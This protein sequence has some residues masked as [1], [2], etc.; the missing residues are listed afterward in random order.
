MIT[1]VK[2]MNRALALAC[3]AAGRTS[4]NPMVGCVIVRRGR[5]IAEG[6][7]KFC[8][9]DHAEV[10]ALKN[11][12]ARAKGADMYVTLEPCA[13]TGRTPPC[14]DAVI[15][16]G[17]RRIIIAMKDPDPRTCGRSIKKLRSHGIEVVTGVGEEQAREINAAFIKYMTSGL[18]Y[19]VAKSAQSM[20]GK[21]GTRSGRIRW[22]TAPATRMAGRAR[23][24]GFDAIVVG[25]NTVLADDPALD[26]PGKRIVKV[27]VDTTLRIP[28]KA[29]IFAGTV[30]GQVIAAT[31]SRAKA[32]KVAALWKLGTNVMVCPRGAGGVDLQALFKALAKNGLI[33]ILIEGG[34][35][36]INAALK[37]KIVDRLHLYIA[38][39]ILGHVRGAVA[40][41][42]AG[43]ML[44]QGALEVVSV[45][46]TGSDIFMECDVR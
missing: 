22:I 27:I 21:V 19:V 25:V 13:H 32:D 46:K 20:D 45:E 9:G 17:I 8:G 12:G 11:A 42:D 30:P 15:A 18:P 1:D 4:P 26:A 7:H 44:R 14:V 5:V 38:P 39:K 3:R 31:T 2:H 28:L 34:P 24:S 43:A 36:L 6:W 40:G 16:A 29:R 41:V 35:T 10:D 37:A 23:R 33:R